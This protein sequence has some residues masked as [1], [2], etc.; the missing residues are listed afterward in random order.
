MDRTDNIFLMRKK[1]FQG[2]CEISGLVLE[3]TT[4]F[5]HFIFWEVY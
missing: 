2:Y 1:H 3:P 5:N 4:T